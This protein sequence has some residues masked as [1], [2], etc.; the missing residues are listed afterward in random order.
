MTPSQLAKLHS[1]RQEG[2]GDTAIA[3]ALGVTRHAVRVEIAILQSG[4]Q[5]VL[6]PDDLFTLP[7]VPL[8]ANEYAARITA[9]WRKSAE[10]FVTIGRLLIHAKAN[11][12]HGEW[13]KL[14]EDQLPFDARTAQRLMAVAADER[15]SNPTLASHLP[16]DWT[17]QYAI[18]RL[19]SKAIEAKIADGTINP[20][21]KRADILGDVKKQ[22]RANREQ[23]LGAMQCALPQQKFGVILAD[24]EWR[25]EPWSRLTGMDRSAD[26][27]YPTSCTEVIAARDVSSIAADDSV[28]FLYATIPMLPHGLVVM[29]AW[30]FDYKSHYVWGK[31]KI[32]SG[33]WNREKH[34][35]LLIGTRGNIPCPAPGT[36]WDSLVIAPRG[37]HSAK[38]E[39]FLEMIEQYFPTLPKIELNR[40]GPARIGWAA[41]GNEA[42][43]SE[44]AE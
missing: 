20:G 24:P 37:E 43:A 27:H 39:I 5:V 13:G 31:D 10:A 11:L 32:G 22:Q 1:L 25:F 7:S 30:G 2:K 34:E 41:W 4:S 26:N 29:G 35:L 23:T 40:R 17:T 9:C 36:Q 18:T 12:E 44:A 14:V 21:M 16:P 15:L 19:D 42:Q 33:Y 28:L 38:P 8:Q 3:H 6:A